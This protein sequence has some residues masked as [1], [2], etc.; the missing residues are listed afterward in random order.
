MHRFTGT[1]LKT[2]LYLI[3]LIAFVPVALLIVYVAEEQKTLETEAVLHKTRLLT[4]AAADEEN[5]QVATAITLLVAVD[6]A[7][8]ASGGNAGRLAGMLNALSVQDQGYAALGIVDSRGRLLAGSD[9]QEMRADYG[10]QQ[11]LVESLRDDRVTM[12]RYHGDRV[13]KTP[14]LYIARRLSPIESATPAVAFVALDL[15]WMNRTIFRQIAGLP[16]GARLTLVDENRGV[17][18]YD[19]DGAS[20]SV[21]ETLDRSLL[22]RVT[23]QP[24]GTFV[25]TD[26]HG[27]PRIF[28]FAR[29]ES[30]FRQRRVTVVLEI[31]QKVALAA[32][33]RIFTRN[34]SLLVLSALVALFSIWWAANRYILG[35]VGTMVAATR[36]LA[37]GD[38]KARIGPI[39]PH[40][41][42][43]HLA[44]VFDEMATSLQM[45]IEREE[46]AL[47]SLERSREQLRRLSAYQNEVREQERLCIAREIHDQLGQSLTILKMDLGWLKKRLPDA[48]PELVEKTIAMAETIETAMTELHAV[49]TELRPVI[50]DDFGLAAA[51]EWQADAFSRRSGIACHIEN[52]GFEPDLPK[53]QATALFRIFQETLTNILRHAEADT[54]TVRLSA[55]DGKLIFQV[56]D[57]GR[58][59]S[60][61]E[62]NAPDAFGLL[63]IRERLYPFGGR[64]RFFG[65]PGEGTTVAIH[66]PYSNQGD[67]S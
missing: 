11:W 40:D 10:G 54:V 34:L 7:F 44:S 12:G 42:L 65:R 5:Q 26:E 24:S 53:G 13:G 18:R 15:N 35:R 51:I 3:V 59:I 4:Q 23:T 55:R 33:K 1:S 61:A 50:L 43:Q 8:Q 60:A 45:R 46:Q 67:R 28:A 58:G 47:A 52:N 14:V 27:L 64:V 66:L 41:E 19:V 48:A 17:M 16:E 2:R 49:T 37:D 39:G 32:S 63:G 56:T 62:I 9:A 25:A 38:L 29:L 6:E 21:P 31:P 20:W 36:R 57:N 22:Q 30:V